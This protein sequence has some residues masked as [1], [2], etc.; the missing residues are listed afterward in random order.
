M[1]LHFET[2]MIGCMEL[3]DK[4][5]SKVE[6][7]LASKKRL[8]EENERLKK[9][10]ATGYAN[11]EEQVAQLGGELEQERNARAEVLERLDKLLEKLKSSTD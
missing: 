8:Q 7:L 3:L 2:F 11:L 9:E 10:A 1:I 5:E 4:L 6:E